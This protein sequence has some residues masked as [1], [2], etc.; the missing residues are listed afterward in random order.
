MKVSEDILSLIPYKPGKPISE[1]QREYGVKDVYKLA[2]N[3]NP[4]GASPKA[5]EAIK[6]ALG[7]LHRYPDA[8]AFDLIQKVSKLWKTPA[9]TLCIGNGSNEL[10]DLLI[11]IFCEPKESILT[12]QGAF[13]AYQVC[14][15]AARVNRHFIP[16]KSDYSTDLKAMGKF[17]QESPH[18]DSVR[19]VF[20][21]NPNNPTGSYIPGNEV[22]DF[23]KI[24]QTKKNLM[25]VFDEAYNEFV[26]AKDY[27]P[28][29]ELMSKYSNI[30][31]IRTLSKAYGLAG[32]R[33]GI[34]VAKPEEIELVNRVRNPFNV[35][36]LAQ[37]AAGA[38]LEDFDFIR[39]SVETTWQGLD[40]FYAQLKSMDLPFI[41]S[42]GNFVMFDTLRDVKQVNESLLKRGVILRPIQNYGF[43][44]HLRMSVG[45]PQENEIAIKALKEVFSEIKPLK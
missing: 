44:T 33:V 27:R 23:L 30:C 22:E 34:L 32:L 42:Q 36:E 3:E 12:S 31:V 41:P 11:R 25:V 38:A 29:Q 37:V 14:A 17:L 1:T 45:L 15:Q 16:L 4:L 18:A 26:R 40:Y 39:K 5:L 6:H 35:N 8:G 10:I 20:I 9:N 24:A 2:S 28:A 21:P 43:M 19:L 13:V 7:S